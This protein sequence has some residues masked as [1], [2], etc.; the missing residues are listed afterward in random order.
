MFCM[1]LVGNRALW[2]DI[3]LLTLQPHTTF[4]EKENFRYK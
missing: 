4:D 3:F 2:I 1:I